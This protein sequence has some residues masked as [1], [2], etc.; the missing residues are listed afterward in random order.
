MLGLE[1]T[2]TL[3]YWGYGTEEVPDE[4]KNLNVIMKGRKPK[5]N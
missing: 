5:C 2:D 1:V 4:K 3:L